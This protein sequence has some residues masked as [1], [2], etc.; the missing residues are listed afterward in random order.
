MVTWLT[1]STAGRCLT[2][3]Q[4]P[5]SCIPPLLGWKGWRAVAHDMS[6][7]KVCTY[8]ARGPCQP[9]CVCGSMRCI[10]VSVHASCPGPSGTLGCGSHVV[11]KATHLPA[12][13]APA[14]HDPAT[15]TTTTT[16]PP[17]SPRSTATHIALTYVV[18]G[19]AH[20]AAW[21]QLPRLGAK[22]QKR[23]HDAAG[24]H[25]TGTLV[26]TQTTLGITHTTTLGGIMH[27][28]WNALCP[29]RSPETCSPATLLIPLNHASKA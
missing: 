20:D 12:T 23:L 22:R 5:M 6:W 28:L 27:A 29:C 17:S 24:S 16:C 3:C 13:H 11:H 4:L 25:N 15:S 2:P 26:V 21:S 18:G 14:L 9:P 1:A 7:T 19:T 10:H 8:V